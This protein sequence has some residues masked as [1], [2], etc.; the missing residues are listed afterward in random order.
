MFATLPELVRLRASTLVGRGDTSDHVDFVLL[1]SL[2]R[3]REAK[4]PHLEED[5]LESMIEAVEMCRSLE[6]LMSCSWMFW[7]HLSW[8]GFGTRTG[9]FGRSR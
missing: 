2:A 3:Q 1:L 9:L 4:L 7:D 5:E 8:E 6:I